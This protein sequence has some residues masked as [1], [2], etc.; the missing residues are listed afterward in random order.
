[1]SKLKSPTLL[2]SDCYVHT[3]PSVSLSLPLPLPPSNSTKATFWG[4]ALQRSNEHTALFCASP[5]VF[6]RPCTSPL[7]PP[8]HTRTCALRLFLGTE[9]L[10]MLLAHSSGVVCHT[11]LSS[12]ALLWSFASNPSRAC[13][14][15]YCMAMVYYTIHAWRGTAVSACSTHCRPVDV[16]GRSAIAQACAQRHESVGGFQTSLRHDNCV[17]VNHKT[18]T[19]ALPALRIETLGEWRA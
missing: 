5:T 8:P 4:S 11:H 7:A 18:P 1:M 6:F 19:M 16:V 10:R 14:H 12:H 17:I 2:Q 15:Y 3:Y 9:V 13:P